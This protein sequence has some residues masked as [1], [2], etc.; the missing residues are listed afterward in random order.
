MYFDSKS[1]CIFYGNHIDVLQR[2]LD[3]DFLCGRDPSV[4]AIIVNDQYPQPQKVFFGNKEIFVPQ[5]NRWQDLSQYAPFDTLINFA[6]YRTAPSVIK[7]AM[8]TK[9]F[10]NIFTVAEGIPEKDTRE[11]IAL[12]KQYNINL[13]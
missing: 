7:E 4:K 1:Y 6:S 3:Y 10:Q 8:Q 12:N 9:L 5:V 13:I 2:M 11:I